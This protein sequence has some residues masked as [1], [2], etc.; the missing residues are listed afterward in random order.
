M[1]LI[2]YG[3]FNTTKKIFSYD[4]YGI[5]TLPIFEDPAAAKDFLDI[6]HANY[7]KNTKFQLCH[8]NDKQHLKDII[9]LITIAAADLQQVIIDPILTQEKRP[10]RI[11]ICEN[12]KNIHIYRESLN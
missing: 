11:R 8:C 1:I 6:L 7:D 9:D 12:I 5:H 10:E 3:D 2:S 4:R